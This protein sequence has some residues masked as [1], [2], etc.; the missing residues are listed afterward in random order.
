MVAFSLFFY[1]EP[2]LPG[3]SATDGTRVRAF[4]L[5]KPVWHDEDS[6]GWSDQD[7]AGR[8]PSGSAFPCIWNHSRTSATKLRPTS[9]TTFSTHPDRPVSAA[10]PTLGVVGGSSAGSFLLAPVREA[11]RGRF[12]RR[13][14]PRFGNANAWSR[15]GV[16]RPP[17]LFPLTGSGADASAS[18]ISPSPFRQQ[19]VDSATSG[20]PLSAPAFQRAHPNALGVPLAALAQSQSCGQRWFSRVSGEKQTRI[21]PPPWED[22]PAAPRD[23]APT[24]A[25]P[26]RRPAPIRPASPAA[27]TA[28]N[29][30]PAS[31]PPAS[32]RP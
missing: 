3:A 27:P 1:A 2:I 7:Y 10:T 21:Q 8:R 18:V 29:S 31:C 16:P 15:S 26:W 24:S 6:Q 22:A 4:E 32:A 30:S 14:K 19:R 25:R 9:A 5:P 28:A 23:G 17:K 12:V 11:S 20:W 13:S